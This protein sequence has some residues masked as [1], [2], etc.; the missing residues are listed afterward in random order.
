MRGE[1]RESNWGF[2]L[3]VSDCVNAI[4]LKPAISSTVTL[5]SVNTC[6]NKQPFSMTRNFAGDEITFSID[7][8]TGDWFKDFRIP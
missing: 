2:L 5:N 4:N 8:F 6:N 7:N 3:Q 1:V